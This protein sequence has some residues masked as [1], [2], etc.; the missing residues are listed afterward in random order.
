MPYVIKP[1]LAEH[2]A[3]A[4]DATAESIAAALVSVGLEEEEIHTSGI[5]GPLVVGRV[6]ELTPEPQKN[7]KTINWCQVEVG[8]DAPRGIVCG[9]H[10]FGVGD[11]VVVALP[12]AVLPGDFAIA[13]RKTYGHVSDGMICSTEELGMGPDPEHGILVLARAGEAG[14]ED[15][16]GGATAEC[17]V[18]APGTDALELLGLAEEVLEINITPDRGYC[19]SMRGVAREYA[20]A[21]G[22]TFTDPGLPAPRGSAPAVPA[23][24]EDGFAIEVADTAPINGEVGCDRF[25]ARIV[26]G[27]DPAAP[28]PEWLQRRL[29]QAGMRPI[30][31]AVDATNYVMLDLGQPL[32]AYDLGTL[33]APIVVRRAQEGERLRTL[34][35]VDRALH[36]EDLLITDSPGGNPGPARSASRASWV[37]RTRRSP[38]PRRTCSSR[39]PTSIRSPSPAPPAG[40]SCRARPRAASSVAWTPS[41]R[42]SPR[43][44]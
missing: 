42:P 37:V 2:V 41:S 11:S 1:W 16:S 34:D 33:A 20:H 40:T 10:N 31:L 43:S 30:S 36:P 29:R 32:H 26:R 39:P 21:T 27:I 17:T 8:E 23:P 24:T 13:S 28:S 3:V 5:T 12:G 25:V 15:P 14:A 6:L 22:A 44:A 35:D 4:E 38:P 9:A 19:F 7:G 18:P